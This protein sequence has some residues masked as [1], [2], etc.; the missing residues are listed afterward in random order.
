[1]SIVFTYPKTVKSIGGFEID[2]FITEHYS[3]SNKVTEIPVEEGSVISDHVTQV[4][5]EIQIKAFIGRTEFAVF[6]GDIPESNADIEYE[7]PQARIIN[8]YHELL[9]LKEDRQ[10]IDLMTGS[11]HVY[12]HDNCQ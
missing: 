11:W 12:E 3:H 6:G 7:D 9:R 5:D 8:A 1:M 4:A 2:A 10:P